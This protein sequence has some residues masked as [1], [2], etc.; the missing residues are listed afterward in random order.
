[1][2]PPRVLVVSAD[3]PVLNMVTELLRTHGYEVQGLATADL[4]VFESFLP[5]AVVVDTSGLPKADVTALHAV[6]RPVMVITSLPDGPSSAFRLQA[7]SFWPLPLDVEPFL[8]AV[9]AACLSEPPPGR[10]HLVYSRPERRGPTRP[11]V[12]DVKPCP[13]CDGAMRFYEL[14]ETGAAWVCRNPDCM[15]VTLVRASHRGSAAEPN[16]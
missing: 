8:R 11:K 1:M 16:E 15:V 14:P 6:D 2:D 7:R 3:A 10:P 9:N 12:G 5:D 4:D 13:N